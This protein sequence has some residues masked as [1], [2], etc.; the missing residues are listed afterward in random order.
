MTG[1]QDLSLCFPLLKVMKA[2]GIGSL[3]PIPRAFS[4]FIFLF[5]ALLGFPPRV[6]GGQYLPLRLG[7]TPIQSDHVVQ[8][9]DLVLQ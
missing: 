7:T 8:T 3:E 2:L 9:P 1:I 6:I 5:H 4:C